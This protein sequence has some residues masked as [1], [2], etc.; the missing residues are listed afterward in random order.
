[1]KDTMQL[2]THNNLLFN[3]GACGDDGER[4][5]PDFV[6]DQLARSLDLP[7]VTVG[8]LGVTFKAESDD[9]RDSLA[10]KLIKILKFRGASV[11]CSD[12]YFKHPGYLSKEALVAG[13]DAVIIGA[14]HRAYYSTVDSPP[15]HPKSAKRSFPLRWLRTKSVSRRLM[16]LSKKRNCRGS[17]PPFTDFTASVGLFGVARQFSSS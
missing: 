10:F 3:I 12:E 17:L 4:G 16:F 1:M 15:P 2:F 13:S 11:L 8:V 6:V 7:K 14:P 5:L 9:I